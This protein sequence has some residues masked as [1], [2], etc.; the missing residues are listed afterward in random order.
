M[1]FVRVASEADA[2]SIATLQCST[3]RHDYPD[4][5]AGPAGDELNP[6]SV[7]DRWRP[8]LRGD[9]P[10]FV[11]VATAQDRVV[12]FA[13]VDVRDEHAEVHALVVAPGERRFGHGSRLMT[14]CADLAQ[15]HGAKEASMWCLESDPA[16]RTF[17]ES[18]GWAV[19]GGRREL[20]DDQTVVSELRYATTF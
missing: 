15:Q 6:E 10:G 17:V 4:L 1:N 12:G 3:W 16:L 2:P 11:L 5:F 9:V 19:D 13:A 8:A 18:S 20:S 7:A 14:A